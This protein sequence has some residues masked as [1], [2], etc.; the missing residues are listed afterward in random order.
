MCTSLSNDSP[1]RDS[2]P[3]HHPIPPFVA[4]RPIERESI[5]RCPTN[6]FLLPVPLCPSVPPS[7]P[8]TR[9]DSTRLNSNAFCPFLA[10]TTLEAGHSLT[11]CLLLPLTWAILETVQ[12]S[13][14]LFLLL[15]N[16]PCF[17]P[18]APPFFH[19]TKKTPSLLA[20]PHSSPWSTTRARNNNNQT[21]SRSFLESAPSICSLSAVIHGTIASRNTNNTDYHLLQ[22]SPQ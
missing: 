7:T 9:L 10:S 16:T 4:F 1:S 3:T 14:L 13:T 5:R 22:A 17:D 6:T 21:S 18:P 12:T 8:N 20:S 19:P 11:H 2:P 15:T